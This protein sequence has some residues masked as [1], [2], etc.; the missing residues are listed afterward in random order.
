MADVERFWCPRDGQTHFDD[1]GF[2][3]DP[4]DLVIGRVSSNPDALSTSE[5]QGAR[6][7]VMLGEMGS[8]KS[9]VLERLDRIVPPGVQPIAI[10]LAP[11]GSEVRLVDEVLRTSDIEQW[12]AGTNELA[13]VLDGFDEAQ[14][15]IPQLG[16]IFAEAIRGWPTDRLLIRIAS[17]TFD[18]SLLLER[19][20]KAAYTDLKVV[21]LLPLR[22][23]DTRAIAAELCDDPEGFLAAVDDM[24]ASAFASRPQT[25]RM[26]AKSYQR[27]GTL[28]NR[29]ADLYDRGTKSLAEEANEGRLESGLDGPLTIDERIAVARRVAAGLTFGRSAAVWAGRQDEVDPEDLLIATIAEGF[30]PTSKGR[31]P[32]TEMGVKDILSTGLFASLGPARLSFAHASFGEFLTAAWIAANSLSDENVRALLIGPDNRTRPQLHGTAAWLIAIAP[33]RFAWLTTVDPEPFLGQV[34]LPNAELRAAVIDGLFTDASRREWGWADK[35]GGLNHEAIAEQV[36]EKIISGTAD[37]Q[38]L[39]VKLVRD[40][41]IVAL[42]PELTNIALDPEQSDRLRC[43][44]ASAVISLESDGPVSDLVP[45]V[46]DESV[47]G[48]DPTDELLG[49]GLTASWPHAI[50]TATVFSFLAAPKLRSYIGAYWRFIYEFRRGLRFEDLPV[51]ISWLEANLEGIESGGFEELADAIIALAAA[52]NIDAGV[53]DALARIATVRASGYEGLGFSHGVARL[54]NDGLPTDSRHR[55]AKAVLDRTTELRVVIYLSARSLLGTGVLTPDDLE[56]I[57]SEAAAAEGPRLEALNR[58][59]GLCFVADRRDHVDLFLDL[60]EDH[61]FR[62]ARPSWVQVELES[63]AAAELREIHEQTTTHQHQPTQSASTDERIVDLLGLIESGEHQAFITLGQILAPREYSVDLTATPAWRALDPASAER[64]IS[65]AEMYLKTRLCNPAD[66]IDEPISF[67]PSAYAGYRA[68]ILLLR[69]R[70]TALSL[71]SV[72]DW[73]EWAPIIATIVC[74]VDGAAWEDKAKLLEYA[75][76]QAHSVLVAALVRHIRA[77]AVAGVDFFWM[78]EVDLLFD[79]D[80]EYLAVQFADTN[81]GP[82]TSGLLKVLTRQRPDRAV[83]V[84][85]SI[86]AE[87]NPNRRAERVT[88]G[89]LLTDCDLADSWGLLKSQFQQDESLALEVLGGAETVRH[90]QTDNFLPEDQIADIYLWARHTFDPTED[91]HHEGTHFVEPREEIGLWRDHLLIALRD[92]GTAAAVQ[93]FATIVQALPGDTYLLR[94]QA[95]AMSVFSQKAWE[96]HTIHELVLLAQQE[97][98]ALVNTEA[99]LQAVVGSA[100]GDIQMLLTG[101]NPQAHLL[102]DTHSSRPKSEDEISD[103]L[104]NQLAD[105]TSRSRLVVN[106]EVQVRRNSPSGIPERADIQVDAATGKPGP[107]ATLSLPIEVKCAWNSELLTAMRSQLVSR[108]MADLHTTHG[109]YVVLWPDIEPWDGSDPR[110]RVVASLDHDDVIEKLTNQAR[111]LSEEG[112]HVE[113]VHLGMEYRRPRRTW[114]QTLASLPRRVFPSSGRDAPAT[115]V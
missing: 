40:C 63:D 79:D 62:V 43:R 19:T 61:P 52:S 53:G 35:L 48:A 10:D 105:L 37:Q 75:D 15:R 99:D 39:A 49:L 23:E 28:P 22:R 92:R 97:Q 41:R 103:Y 67:N 73:M 54:R 12:K 83:P 60:D 84:L 91:P 30:E 58:L 27:Y 106:R 9:R 11:Y 74:M 24:K 42:G 65:A 20:L 51:A 59:F 18:W 29:M 85:R 93:A 45:L 50:S 32:I 2:L 77:T 57:V 31:I 100:F 34:D 110:R 68:L 89:I 66:W 112:M 7:L 78:N 5:L 88:A 94:I 26:L 46:V 113:V 95:L 86:V 111:E 25:L 36:R 71:L 107:Y 1:S 44:A 104:R 33:L 13:L 82:I 8:G 69:A 98:T 72:T 64:I 108:Y 38:L 70:P 101:A 3:A 80:L 4:N 16:Q 115:I 21:E 96:P 56:W 14:E 109:C 81:S 6:A 114:R 76:P 87:Q 102:W 55:L 47:R 90:R 17:R